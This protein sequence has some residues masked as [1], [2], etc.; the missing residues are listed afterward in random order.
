[1]IVIEDDLVTSVGFLR[2]MNQALTLYANEDRVM[3]ISGHMFSI[4]GIDSASDAFFLPMSTSWGWATWQRSWLNFDP[5]A[6]GWEHIR[7]DKLMRYRFD[8]EGSYPYAEMLE[9]QMS[10]AIDTWAIRWWWT[11]FI[12]NGI[13]LFPRLSLVSN[14]GFGES[15]THTT[16]SRK[17]FSDSDWCS[18]R[19]VEAFPRTVEV[20]NPEWALVRAY[21]RR[22]RPSTL[23]RIY[24]QFA[25]RLGINAVR[26]L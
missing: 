5:N 18:D 8:L 6:T 11:C 1:V 20:A 2:Y 7:N 10:G 4:T 17:P 15:A 12:L 13:T 16:S 22:Q 3:Q 23:R 19:R 21:L 14:V 25:K 26:D 24:S 9:R